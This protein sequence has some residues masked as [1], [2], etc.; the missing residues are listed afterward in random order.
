M[1]KQKKHKARVRARQHETGACYTE[2]LYS[3]Q[4]EAQLADIGAAK[5]ILTTSLA[6]LSFPTDDPPIIPPCTLRSLESAKFRT[7]QK[8]VGT[9]IHGFIWDGATVESVP[10]NSYQ[11]YTRLAEAIVELDAKLG[12]G[13]WVFASPSVAKVLGV[14]D[15]R[16]PWREVWVVKPNTDLTSDSV[17]GIVL[18]GEVRW[19]DVHKNDRRRSSP[20]SGEAGH[21]VS[22]EEFEAL[23]DHLYSDDVLAAAKREREKLQKQMD[24]APRTP[25]GAAICENAKTG[26]TRVPVPA[27]QTPEPL[28]SDEPFDPAGSDEY[29]TEH[30]IH[31][32]G[33]PVLLDEHEE[34]AVFPGTSQLKVK[35][36]LERAEKRD[37]AK[38]L[39]RVAK[40]SGVMVPHQWFD[41]YRPDITPDRR[42]QILEAAIITD[43][44]YYDALRHDRLGD[45]IYYA[46][47]QILKGADEIAKSLADPDYSA[48]TDFDIGP[49]VRGGDVLVPVALADLYGKVEEREA[50]VELIVMS[51]RRYGELSLNDGDRMIAREPRTDLSLAGIQGELWGAK[52]VTP[53]GFADV[54]FAYGFDG[55]R[56]FDYMRF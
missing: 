13:C 2:A 9:T 4:S 25:L 48:I 49:G 31:F 22:P 35:E 37:I 16:V 46:L 32:G 17:A 41:F 51:K 38:T 33:F 45:R 29:L 24:E 7:W 15:V 34:Y 50:E 11:P 18:H 28:A 19:A 21:R 10:T 44:D 40:T 36:A 1:T 39:R 12:G 47:Q 26:E 56:A 43:D 55:K 6:S 23:L 8:S 20:G 5:E 27:I 30:L 3:G 53:D 14:C 52:I 54:V 42:E